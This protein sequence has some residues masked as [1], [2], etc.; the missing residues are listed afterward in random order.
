MG[1]PINHTNNLY[2]LWIPPQNPEYPFNQGY[3]SSFVTWMTIHGISIW[4]YSLQWINTD[5]WHNQFLMKTSLP[6]PARV[7]VSLLQ[8]INPWYQSRNITSMTG[9]IYILIPQ[10]MDLFITSLGNFEAFHPHHGMFIPWFIPRPLI[11]ST[12]PFWLVV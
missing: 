6:T 5:P 8:G 3:N 11:R 1:H 12:V 4:I 10:K 7:Y 2:I 9:S